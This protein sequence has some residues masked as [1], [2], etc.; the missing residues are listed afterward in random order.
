M[1]WSRWKESYVRA[2][3][4]NVELKKLFILSKQVS[5]HKHI[6][7][8]LKYKYK[9]EYFLWFSTSFPRT[10]HTYNMYMIV[11]LKKPIINLTIDWDNRFVT[12]IFLVLIPN[13]VKFTLVYKQIR[14]TAE[15]QNAHAEDIKKVEK[16]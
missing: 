2:E 5:L 8:I 12:H 7:N 11:R 14:D 15:T 9:F 13:N 4:L 3:R 6:K 1:S 16:S 10:L